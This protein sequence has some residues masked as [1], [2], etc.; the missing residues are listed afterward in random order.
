MTKLSALSVI[1]V[2]LSGCMAMIQVN[3]HT[4]AKDSWDQSVEK[5][6][7]SAAFESSCPRSSLEMTLLEAEGYRPGSSLKIPTKIGV[8]G[9]G[10]KLVY[11]RP[12]NVTTWMLN[13]AA[14]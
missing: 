7:T 6:A 11:V 4:V 3:G 1:A 2:G 8:T 10:Q 14:K 9:C 13:S 12:A 5:V